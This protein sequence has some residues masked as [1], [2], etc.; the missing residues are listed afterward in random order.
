[1][2][3]YIYTFNICHLR[4][5]CIFIYFKLRRPEFMGN[6]SR[7]GQK[8]GKTTFAK[9]RQRLRVVTVKNQ[10]KILKRWHFKEESY[11]FTKPLCTV[12]AARMHFT[13]IFLSFR[14]KWSESNVPP[15]WRASQSCPIT[16]AFFHPRPWLKITTDLWLACNSYRYGTHHNSYHFV[17]P[18]SR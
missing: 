10:K 12:Y 6:E 4:I 9:N 17:I 13:T 11:K 5:D 8:H 1:M 18:H 16:S 14:H 15:L 2:Y 3:I 7:Q